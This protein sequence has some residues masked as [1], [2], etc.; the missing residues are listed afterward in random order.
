MINQALQTEV[1]DLL[2]RLIACRSLSGEEQG[3][4][5]ILQEYLKNSGFESAQIDR[6]GS[7]VAGVKG[8]K[9]G[10][11]V[12]FDGHVDTVPAEN[13]SDWTTPPF[14][15]TVRDGKLYGRGTS[16]MKGADAAFAVAA[17]TVELARL[18]VCPAVASLPF[19]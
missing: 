16:D 2:K 11:R 7:I 3:V 5:A 1:L 13:A 19:R 14:E 8:S 18:E 17:S 10:K 9:P 15:P 6:F 12:L 4:T